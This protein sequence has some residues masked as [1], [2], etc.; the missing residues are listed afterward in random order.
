MSL[1]EL[2][3]GRLEQAISKMDEADR[4]LLRC[5]ECVFAIKFLAFDRLGKAD[6]A[7]AAGEAY[8]ADRVPSEFLNEA[9]FRPAV[10]QRLGE[11][12]EAKGMPDKALP[13]YQEFVERWKKA[14]PEFQ[15]RVKDVRARIDRIR[16]QVAKK[17]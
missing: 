3:A 17:G 6:S 10:L 16:A 15:P 12:Y 9:L 1:V 13:H 5:R 2:S 4:R 8:V 7:I 11:L 14:D